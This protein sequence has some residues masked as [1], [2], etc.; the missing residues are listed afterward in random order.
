MK[1]MRVANIEFAA[2]FIISAE[3]ISVKSIRSPL[4]INGLYNFVIIS[5]ALSLSTPTTTRS[6]RIKS[7]TAAPS[8]KNSGLEATSKGIFTPLLSSSSIM[9]AFTFWAVPTGTVLFVTKTVY[10]CIFWPNV[11]AT[12][13]TYFKSALPSSSG[14]VPTALKTTSTSSKHSVNSVVKFKRPAEVFFCIIPLSPG[15]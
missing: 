3:G 12:A 6:G 15:S 14:G 13:K 10:F 1:L 2:Y 9:T 4:S 5:F 8:F 7:S 11:R